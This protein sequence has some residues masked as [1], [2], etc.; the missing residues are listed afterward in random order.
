M[1]ETTSADDAS[2]LNSAILLVVFAL[3]LAALSGA[4]MKGL[5]DELPVAVIVALRFLGYFAMI[6]PLALWRAGRAAFRPA[7]PLMQVGRGFLMALST[8]AFVAG[9]RGLDYADAIAILYVYPFLITLMAP[10]VLGER[11]SPV[12]WAG[13]FG[14][15]LGVMLVMRPDFASISVSALYVLI[16]AVS[17]SAQMLLNR[18]LGKLTDPMVTS[19][20]GAGVAMLLLGSQLPWYWVPLSWTQALILVLLA[21][22]AA[23]SQTLVVLAFARAPAA[24]LAPFTYVEIVA[25]VIYGLALF[26]TWPD[27]FSLAGIAL[28]IVSGVL[29]AQAR[30]GRLFLRRH[31]KI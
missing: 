4:L 7:R 20:W 5:A 6:V 17:V 21:A 12:A 28:I 30:S 19:M 8:A 13:V 25:G 9:A 15:F 27:A 24:E 2:A 1:A 29:V 16:C 31:P 22:I 11:V 10:W 14:G 26:G 3:S 23:I 18:S